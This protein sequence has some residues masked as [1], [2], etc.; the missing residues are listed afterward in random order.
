MTITCPECG[1]KDVRAS[2]SQT[3]GEQVLKVFGFFY[4]RCKDCDARFRAQ[5]WDFLNMI[6]ARCPRCYRLDLST[7]ST[8]YYRASSSQ[9][10]CLRLGGRRHRCAYCRVNFVDFRPAKLRYKGK[11]GAPIGGHPQPVANGR[12]STLDESN[13]AVST[14]QVAAASKGADAGSAAGLANSQS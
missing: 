3:I 5:I 9:L 6:Y 1:S 11:L 8:E 12:V 4:L 13:Q 14:A 7:W 10:L 2:L